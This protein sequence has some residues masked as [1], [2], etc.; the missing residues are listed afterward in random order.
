MP[1]A[2]VLPFTL[3]SSKHTDQAMGMDELFSKIATVHIDRSKYWSHICPNMGMDTLLHKTVCQ[4][5]GAKQEE[6]KS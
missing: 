3:R 2:T 4:F 1:T 6:K 5:C